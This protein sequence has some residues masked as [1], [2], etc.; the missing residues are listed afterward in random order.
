MSVEVPTIELGIAHGSIRIGM[1]RGELVKT[2][3]SPDD[4]GGVSRKYRLPRVFRYG[5]VQF[6]FP[7]ARN[8]AEASSQGLEYVYI[9]DNYNVGDPRYLLR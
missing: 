3:G 6:V 9:D 4:E 8:L 1:T 2:L 7:P 5:D